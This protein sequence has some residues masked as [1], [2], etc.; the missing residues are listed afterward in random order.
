MLLSNVKRTPLY[1]YVNPRNTWK[2][3]GIVLFVKIQ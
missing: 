2:L 1:N 3:I